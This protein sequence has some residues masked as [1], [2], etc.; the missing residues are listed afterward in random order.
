MHKDSKENRSG[1]SDKKTEMHLINTWIVEK[2]YGTVANYTL[3]DCY[4]DSIYYVFYDLVRLLHK[5][6]FSIQ[7]TG[8]FPWV[9]TYLKLFF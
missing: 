6:F 1:Q 5:K 8:R 2:L 3:S 9:L 4:A 7:F